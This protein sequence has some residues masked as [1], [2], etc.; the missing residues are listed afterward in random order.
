MHPSFSEMNTL[1]SPANISILLHCHYSPEPLPNWP[2]AESRERFILIPS[3]YGDCPRSQVFDTVQDLLAIGAVQPLET[4]GTFRTTALGR[5]WVK[6]LCDT[7]LPTPA[8]VD[9]MGRVLTDY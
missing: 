5:A 9:Q 7:P 8:F 1:E 3:R 2:D 6:A 4:E